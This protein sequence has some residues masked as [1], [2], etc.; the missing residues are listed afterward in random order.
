MT[1]TTTIYVVTP[2]PYY[3]YWEDRRYFFTEESAKRFIEN[4]LWTIAERGVYWEVSCSADIS[5]Y[6][7]EY[8]WFETEQEA[9]EFVAWMVSRAEITTIEVQQ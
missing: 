5:G 4:D 8:D 9:R 2:D 3:G 6:L 7:T 1:D